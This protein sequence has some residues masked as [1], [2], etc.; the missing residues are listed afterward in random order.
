MHISQHS[1]IHGMEEGTL[2]SE[3]V[4]IIYRTRDVSCWQNVRGVQSDVSREVAP[5]PVRTATQV[6]TS[7]KGRTTMS[8]YK[9]LK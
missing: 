6:P 5:L 4:D 2:F 8:A 3:T 7:V 1:E 9:C